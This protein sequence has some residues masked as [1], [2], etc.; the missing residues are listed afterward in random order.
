[1]SKKENIALLLNVSTFLDERPAMT[2]FSQEEILEGIYTAFNLINGECA[3]LPL[4]VLEYN[5]P[6]LQDPPTPVDTTNELYRTD[7]EIDQFKQAVITQTQYTLNMGNDFSQGSSSFSTGG[8]NASIQ[9]PEKRDILAPG[10]LKFLQNA[11]LYSLQVYSSY[12]NLQKQTN[13]GD[14]DLR[15]VFVTYENGD[16]RYVHQYQEGAAIGSIAVI[17]N[18]RNVSFQNPNTVTFKGMDADKILDTDGNYKKIHD[19]ANLAFYGP[20]G[21]DATTHNELMDYVQVQKIY[22]PNFTYKSGDIVATY[23]S[24]NNKLNYWKSNQHNNKGNDPINNNA[25]FFWWTPI[26]DNNIQAKTIWDPIDQVYKLINQFNVE[27][28]GGLTK[29]QIYSA[30]NASGTSWNATFSYRKDFVVIFV[31]SSNALGWY[32]SLQDNNIGHNPETETTWWKKLPTPIVDIND[33]ILQI[34]PYL[35]QEITKKVD[36]EIQ[37]YSTQSVGE[38]EGTVFKFTDDNAFNTFIAHNPKLTA[39]M[40][41]DVPFDYYTKS[42][43]DAANQQLNTK[44]QSID[45]N[46]NTNTQNITNNTGKISTNAT[47]ITN[48]DNKLNNVISGLQNGNLIN[49]TGAWSSSKTYNIGQ[50]VTYNDKW[51]V[52]NLN[53]NTNHTPQSTSDTWWEI[54]SEP[55]I[56]LTDYYTKVESDNRFLLKTMINTM[57]PVGSVVMTADGSVHAMVTA[58]PNKFTEITDSD[59]SYLAIGSGS[60]GTSN[61]GTFTIQQNNLPNIYWAWSMDWNTGITTNETNLQTYTHGGSARMDISNTKESN[62]KNSAFSNNSGARFSILTKIYLNGNVA[63]TP[64]N[65]NIKPK[66]LKIRMWRV[67]SQLV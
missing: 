45:S 53:N 14:C 19:V 7:F 67:I 48:I 1:M 24:S 46:I 3:N 47:N 31:D 22:S 27:Y 49:Y 26:I 2:T 4:K 62:H 15:N 41:E 16:K 66:T 65:L 33:I 56:N 17:D 63:Q 59:V 28:F 51:Y 30:I 57:F 43:T 38:Y 54:L 18:N 21:Q 37:K 35:D 61:T 11:R 36:A 12:S 64:I 8:L 44:L 58:Y 32:Q 50:C 20:D 40:F 55:S 39:N 29:D 5:A 13:Y 6:A 34:T 52:S 9:R 60:G 25:S 42:E 10:V 23:D